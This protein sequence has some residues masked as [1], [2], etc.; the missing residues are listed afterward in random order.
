MRKMQR[1]RSWFSQQQQL[2]DPQPSGAIAPFW[3]NGARGFASAMKSR[4]NGGNIP[5]PALP[6]VSYGERK[7]VLC[8][9]SGDS[10]ST[11]ALC[12]NDGTCTS[13]G[14]RKLC[15]SADCAAR[16]RSQESRSR[17]L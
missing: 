4:I 12:E 8:L 7:K 11:M 14:N 10:T 13:K 9:M 2:E 17:L 5:T 6:S 15:G 3:F 16:S 1:Q